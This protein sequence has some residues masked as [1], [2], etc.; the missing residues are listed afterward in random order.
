MWGSNPRP[1]A[2]KTHTLTTE[3]I[4]LEKQLN[5][6]FINNTFAKDLLGYR[7]NKK[8]NSDY[9]TNQNVTAARG[10][11]DDDMNIQML[12]PIEYG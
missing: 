1:W 7:Q 6:R 8:T 11:D 3:L 9:T 2:H 12:S 5:F 4:G 10:H